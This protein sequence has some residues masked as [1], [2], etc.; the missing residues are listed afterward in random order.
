VSPD[1]KEKRVVVVAL[2]V[3]N[4]PALEGEK[5]A[6]QLGP[7]NTLDPI[8]DFDWSIWEK[9][10]SPAAPRGKIGEQQIKQV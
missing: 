8:P 9:S 6:V 7:K 5:I 10:G 2:K 4:N 3:S 1:F